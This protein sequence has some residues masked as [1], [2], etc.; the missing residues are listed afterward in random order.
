[1]LILDV[2]ANS[3]APVT[4][5]L[6]A[7]FGEIKRNFTLKCNFFVD[8]TNKFAVTGANEFANTFMMSPR[9]GF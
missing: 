5:N 4:A 6:F 9:N 2:F 7:V 3:F 1:M 8:S